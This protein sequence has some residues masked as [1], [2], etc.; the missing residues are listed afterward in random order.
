MIKIAGT[1]LI[2]ALFL[3]SEFLILAFLVVLVFVWHIFIDR[4]RE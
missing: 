1:T 3:G 2:A 4:M